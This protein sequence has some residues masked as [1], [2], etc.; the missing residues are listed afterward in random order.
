VLV[1]RQRATAAYWFG[2]VNPL[3]GFAIAADRSLCFEDLAIAYG[4][5]P[6]PP[7]SYAVTRSDFAGHPLH[8]VVRTAPDPKGRACTPPLALA[9]GHESY[10]IIEITTS[11][12][13]F[14]GSTHVH[15]AADSAGAPRVIGIWRP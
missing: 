6:A 1:A 2:Q 11:R 10:T 5:A 7:T 13:G 9:T 4:F 8:G 12:P 15:V 14:T 3:D